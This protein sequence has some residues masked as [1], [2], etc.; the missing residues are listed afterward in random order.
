MVQVIPCFVFGPINA[1]GPMFEF[2][3]SEHMSEWCG[4][5]TKSLTP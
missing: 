3:G 5:P 2:Q 4:L 1:E